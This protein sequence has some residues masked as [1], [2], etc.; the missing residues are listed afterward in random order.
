MVRGVS[1]VNMLAAGIEFLAG[2]PEMLMALCA[3]AV[4]ALVCAE[5]LIRPSEVGEN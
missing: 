1:D 4:V 2:K 5:R 3:L